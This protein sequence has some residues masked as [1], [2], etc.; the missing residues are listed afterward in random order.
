MSAT[1]TIYGLSSGNGMAGVAVVRMSGP[2]AGPVLKDVA[3]G[4]PAARVFSLRKLKNSASGELIDVAVVVWCPGPGSAT[5]EDV[6]EFQVHGSRAVL[7]ELFSAFGGVA[8]VRAAEPGEFTRRAYSNG[9]MDLVEVEGLA[10]LLASRTREQMRQ[11]IGQF[12][13]EAS[14]VFEGWRAQLIEIIAAVEAAIDFSEEDG[15]AGAALANLE[16]QAGRLVAA[17][18]KALR[19]GR[20][21]QVIRDGVKVVLCGLPNTGKS[22]LLNVLAQREAAIV[23]A[24]PGTTR[25][26]I[27]VQLDLSGIPV[28]LTD[29]AGLRV[30]SPDEIERI[31]MARSRLEVAGG[32]VVVWV[33]SPDI[34]GSE[35]V[36]EGVRPDLLIGNKSDLLGGDLRLPRNDLGLPRYAVSS[37][38]GS[39]VDA[40]LSDLAAM[41]ARCY[42]SVEQPVVVR[43]RQVHAIADSIRYLNDAQRHGSHELELIAADLRGAADAL[44]RITGRIGVEEWL[45]AIFSRFCIGK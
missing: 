18:E 13:G 21:A 36:E 43:D 40:F 9:K 38:S 4:L 32:D 35:G 26:V 25:D 2:L 24:I 39:G 11:A 37:K 31:G 42:G 1:D 3:G 41:A 6:A 16:R 15:V 10:D 17:M 33:S 14:G 20:R 22:S 45:G 19:E 34:E 23:S 7:A 27:E 29:T 12:S 28:I 30:E 5:G 44:G 8:G